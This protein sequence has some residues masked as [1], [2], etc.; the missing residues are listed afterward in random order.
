[1]KF[2]INLLMLVILAQVSLNAAAPYGSNNPETKAAVATDAKVS[3]AKPGNTPAVNPLAANLPAANPLAA[4]PPAAADK[5]CGCGSTCSCSADNPSDDCGCDACKCGTPAV[6]SQSPQKAVCGCGKNC[7]C[8]A[9]NPAKNCG[10]KK[11]CGC[12]QKSSDSAITSLIERLRE[13]LK[14]MQLPPLRN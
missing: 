5:D 11:P 9:N 4:S 8:E 14:S 3:S 10:C 6:A 13:L 1:M 7:Q 2:V 12:G